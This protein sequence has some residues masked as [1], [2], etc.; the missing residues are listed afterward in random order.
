[1]VDETPF[2]LDMEISYF[3]ECHTEQPTSNNTIGCIARDM[4]RAAFKF[5][6]FFYE[7]Y[8]D[9]NSAKSNE[10]WNRIKPLL[11]KS[12]GFLE[13][14]LSLV[15]IQPVSIIIENEIKTEVDILP[16]RNT[17]NVSDEISAEDIISLLKNEK[18]ICEKFLKFKSSDHPERWKQDTH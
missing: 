3:F 4:R 18:Q 16:I 1:M 10:L 7:D 11:E 13:V 8:N 12:F 6:E 17:Q 14:A 2:C 5:A 9:I 15:D